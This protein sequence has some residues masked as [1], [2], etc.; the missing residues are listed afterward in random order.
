[1]ARRNCAREKVA[2]DGVV[3]GLGLRRRG[4]GTSWILQTRIRGR[5]VKRVIAEG[6]L[7][8][9]QARARAREALAELLSSVEATPDRLV[10]VAQ[11]GARFMAD[12]AAG[13]S[14]RTIDSNRAA[15]EAEIIPHLGHKRLCDVT[16]ADVITWRDALTCSPASKNRHMAVLSGMMRHAELLDLRPPGSNP[17]KGLRRRKS[18]F[19]ASYL[20]R[21]EFAAVGAALRAL[22]TRFAEEVAL[23]RFVALTG[24][25]KGEALSLKWDWL[26]GQRFALPRSKS[27]PR[28]IW[29][30]KAALALVKGQ[31][32]GSGFVFARGRRAAYGSA[33]RSGLAAAA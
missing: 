10:T 18:Q 9:P 15:V 28:S 21:D 2:W 19:T 13:W 22:E 32:R 6:T 31:A 30:G 20:T 3:K 33:P 27:G 17:C 24:C 4:K 29:L 7:P 26:D 25:R 5:S 1:M 8:R 14:A 11:F 23:L 16:R 12:K